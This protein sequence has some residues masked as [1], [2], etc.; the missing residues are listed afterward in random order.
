MR[1]FGRCGPA[2][3]VLPDRLA[4]LRVDVVVDREL[5]GTDL[6]R[7]VVVAAPLAVAGGALQADELELVGLA[8]ELGTGLV[9]GD[10]TTHE[11]LARTDDPRHLLVERLQRLGRERLGDVEVVVEAVGDGRA[12]AEL[13][14]G[15][16]RLHGLGEHVGGGV[17]Q[18]VQPIGRI[19]R[20]R[21]DDV[22]VGHRRREVLELAVDAHRD[23]G[24]IGEEREAVS[25]LDPLLGFSKTNPST[26]VV[27]RVPS[28]ASAAA[29]S[30]DRMSRPRDRA[31]VSGRSLMRQPRGSSRV[32]LMYTE[33]ESPFGDAYD[34]RIIGTGDFEP[35]VSVEDWVA[36]YR[37]GDLV[38]G[39]IFWTAIE[40]LT[41][42]RT[43][44]KGRTGLTLIRPTILQTDAATPYA[45]FDRRESP[46]RNPAV[47]V[48]FNP[49]AYGATGPGTYVFTFAVEAF[50]YGRVRADRLR[51]QRR[52]GC[53]GLGL[54]Q[55]TPHDHRDP[56]ERAARPGH[57]GGDRADIGRGLVVVQ[58]PHQPSAA[59]A[60]GLPALGRSSA[61]TTEAPADD[62][63]FVVGGRY[64]DRTSDLFRV[65]EARYRCANRPE[66]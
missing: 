22:V 54:V 48:H 15:V 6:D 66:P 28:R 64:W 42:T 1:V 53:R 50:G 58:H 47:S 44:G 40:T 29:P 16:D 37:L 5:T 65:R 4:R 36:K 12:D 14:L 46:N 51:G 18:D 39:P 7:F 32:F 13:G 23:N 43:I 17:P 60:R 61:P 30:G 10:D 19:D 3:E 27:R 45:G 55:R 25:H 31:D 62:R 33:K 26:V 59:R 35:D 20:D 41:P 21:L 34:D 57:M 52:R 9:V 2:A 11:S 49:G 63:G 8:R 56:A 24:T 38:G